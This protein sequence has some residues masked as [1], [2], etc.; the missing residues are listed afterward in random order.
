MTAAKNAEPEM[1]LDEYMEEIV[2]VRLPIIPGKEKQEAQFVAVNGREWVIPRGKD[3]QIPRY[4]ALVLQEAEEEQ[5]KA[6][7]YQAEAQYRN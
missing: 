4:A 2:T 5:L 7:Q 6:L 3:F 1:N